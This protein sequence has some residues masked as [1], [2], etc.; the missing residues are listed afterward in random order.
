MEV[1]LHNKPQVSDRDRTEEMLE[2]QSAKEQTGTHTLHSA[3]LTV[4]KC[5]A[6]RKP[7]E[8][9]DDHEDF[10]VETVS[11]LFYFYLKSF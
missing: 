9:S 2:K 4:D 1:Y 11:G 6:H 5:S 10:V 8:L 7:L 3:D